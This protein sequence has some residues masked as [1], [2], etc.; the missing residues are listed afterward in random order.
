VWVEGDRTRLTQIFANLLNNAAKY[1]PDGG[2][3]DLDLEIE[4]NAAIIHVRDN[5]QGIESKLLPQIF[6]LFTQA[7][8]SPDRAQ[9]GLGIGLALV[10]SLV[11]LHGGS[12]AVSSEGKDCGATF[13]V[14][15]PAVGTR[16]ATDE[17]AQGETQ[18]EE[19][20]DVVVV[21]DNI[22]AGETLKVLLEL[23][24]H[25]V[26]VFHRAIDALA[27]IVEDPPD[28]A[29]LDIGLPDITGHQLAKEILERLGSRAPI[30]AALSGYGQPQDLAASR[31]A[32]LDFHLIKPP[33]PAKL[34]EVLRSA[35]PPL[36]R[37]T[38]W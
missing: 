37:V 27:N 25:R 35:T 20:L 22:D 32:G 30:L 18:L 1:T 34:Q 31:V 5:G 17:A 16:S 13:T 10:R 21:D 8:R 28:V 23:M 3:V 36:A 4:G 9:G 26:R 15:L 11:A 7:E 14:S 12:I 24:G 2:E 29:F 19:P 33:D 6:D 38:D